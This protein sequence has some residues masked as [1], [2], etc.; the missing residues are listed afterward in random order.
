[1]NQYVKRNHARYLYNAPI[2][3]FKNQMFDFK[4]DPIE[5]NKN[6]S[7]KDSDTEQIMSIQKQKNTLEE[8]T[9][10][11]SKKLKIDKLKEKRQTEAD[12]VVPSKKA[13]L[14]EEEDEL[15][16]FGKSKKKPGRPKGSKKQ[17]QTKK[18]DWTK[19]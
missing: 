3:R 16:G 19:K 7:Q 4:V 18:K 13:K 5:S 1:M 17:K 11:P 9:S 10:S 2:V 6:L 12:D 8:P 15:E 14:S